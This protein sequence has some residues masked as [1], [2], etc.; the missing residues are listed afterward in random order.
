ME[1]LDNREAAGV[2]TVCFGIITLVA[3]LSADA[4]G[5]GNGL[6]WGHYQMAGTILGVAVI[7][8]GLLLMMRE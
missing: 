1:Q 5:I 7:V 8:V 4:L 2:A 6:D 3:S